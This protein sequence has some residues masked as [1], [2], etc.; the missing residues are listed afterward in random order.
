[1]W[2]SRNPRLDH[3]LRN[4]PLT[5]ALTQYRSTRLKHGTTIPYTLR[6]S[7]LQDALL[8]FAEVFGVGEVH[9]DLDVRRGQESA[10][11]T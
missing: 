10:H 4:A 5:E 8:G 3:Q 11:A 6:L 1:M 7:V 2:K 9:A